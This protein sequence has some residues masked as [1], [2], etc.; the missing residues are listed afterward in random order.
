MDHPGPGPGAPGPTP[1]TATLVARLAGNGPLRF[2]D[3]MDTVLYDP[4]AGFYAAGGRAGGRAGDFVTSPETGPL[5]GAVVARAVDA[6][7][8]DAGQPDVFTVAEAGAGPGTLAASIRL[9]EPRCAA[10]LRWVMVERTAVQ[11]VGHVERLGATVDTDAP[12]RTD[13][14]TLVSTDVL[15]QSADVVVANEL[16]DNL[17]TRIACRIGGRW[18]EVW[19]ASEAGSL[20]FAT[21]PADPDVAN[22]LDA[23]VPGADD[24]QWVPVQQRAAAWLGR[25]LDV[26]G[27][28][29]RVVVIDYADS[30]ASMARRGR[31]AWLR[32]YVAGGR[33]TGPL[34]DCGAQDVTCDVAV[35]QLAR[36]RPPDL[37]SSQARFLADHG[38]DDL[39]AEGRR[40]WHQRAP[41]G[42][43][44]AVRARS[45]VS[46]AASLTD[47]AG[48]GA[49][50]VLVWDPQVGSQRSATGA[51]A[52]DTRG[53]GD[54]P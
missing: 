37:N 39:V 35:D 44:A 2:D 30:T 43:L 53:R 23:L 25:A 15:P 29:G 41:V 33:G 16:L 36:V 17:P 5:F 20:V 1:L 24:G 27:A 13:R 26:A 51:P 3:Y 52:P 14:V 11:R 7:W 34:N 38:I 8:D 45:R 4:D 42:D 18:D 10:A 28:A 9:A 22:L 6:W 50:R 32:T 31:D 40:I 49:H 21:V 46:E 47:P 54:T 19:V 48:L 12:A